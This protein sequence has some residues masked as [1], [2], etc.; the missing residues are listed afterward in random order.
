MSDDRLVNPLGEAAL[1]GAMMQDNAVIMEWAGRLQVSDFG[2]PVHGRIY[3]ALVRFAANAKPANEV[4]LFPVF[5]NDSDADYG[6]Y[7]NKLVESPVLGVGARGFAE[8]IVDL[9]A[10]REAREA[11]RHAS[12]QLATEFDKPLAEIIGAAD[13]AVWA[14]ETRSEIVEMLGLDDMV[15]MCEDRD[16]RI[17]ADPG[18]EGMTNALI[19]DIERAIGAP[20]PGTYIIGAGRPGMG[21]TSLATSAGIG[22]A[23]NGHAGIMFLLEGRGEKH[24][25]RVTS[26][27]SHAMGRP[28]KQARLKKGG[29]SS[30]ERRELAEIKKRAA[31]LPLKIV[32]MKSGSDIRRI[33]ARVARE[34]ALLAAKGVVLKWVAIDQ[35]SL[36]GAVNADGKPIEKGFIR[37]STVSQVNRNMTDELGVVT[38]ALAQI[39]RGVEARINKRPNAADLKESGSLEEDCDAALLLF[40]EEVYHREEEPKKD[41]I[42]KDNR[43]LHEQW[44]TD[45]RILEGKV[46]II[47][48]KSRYTQ[49]RPR[50]ANFIGEYFAIRSLDVQSEPHPDLFE[51]EAVS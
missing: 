30:E 43:P 27:L 9:A 49:P 15:A 1:L 24:A 39:G 16:E 35:L 31:L 36:C 10:R 45:L 25:T 20:E 14:A 40:R 26:D 17:N 46:E 4:T 29:L 11:M 32:P 2:E 6:G 33:W 23:M 48:G 28:I 22:W 12:E 47:V 13:E 3:G 8:Q 19:P 44:E 42:G 34:K 38:L 18:S 21:K 37:M 41:A 5:Q 50:T 51:E 7:L